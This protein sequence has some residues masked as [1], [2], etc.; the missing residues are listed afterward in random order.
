[1]DE[2]QFAAQVAVEILDR[3]DEQ[4]PLFAIHKYYPTGFKAFEVGFAFMAGCITA[5]SMILLGTSVIKSA[6]LWLLP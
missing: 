4:E 3:A 6:V 1:M 2:K 5:L